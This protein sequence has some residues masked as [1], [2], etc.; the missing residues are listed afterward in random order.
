ME[1]SRKIRAAEIN[2]IPGIISVLERNLLAFKKA[3]DIE[4]LEKKGFLIQGFTP[5]E[6]KVPILDK[7]HSYPLYILGRKKSKGI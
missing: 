5:E 1:N 2:D 4:T 3:L 6:A 7:E